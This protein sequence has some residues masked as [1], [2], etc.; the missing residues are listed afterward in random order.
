M[1]APEKEAKIIKVDLG[2]DKLNEKGIFLDSGTTETYIPKL[3]KAPFEK[4]SRSF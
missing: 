4:L 1:P 3:T 2:L